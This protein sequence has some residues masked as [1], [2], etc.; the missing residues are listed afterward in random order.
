[1]FYGK[2][3]CSLNAWKSCTI[4]MFAESSNREHR[5]KGEQ[6]FSKDSIEVFKHLEYFHVKANL[7]HCFVFKDRIRLRENWT[8]FSDEHENW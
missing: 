6:R 3:T 7:I 5:N 8:H 1:M 4:E 2:M